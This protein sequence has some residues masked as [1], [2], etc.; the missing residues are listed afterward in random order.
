MDFS[1]PT[2]ALGPML[3]GSMEAVYFGGGYIPG[4][5]PPWVGADMEV[6]VKGG[7][8]GLPL[9][10][11]RAGFVKGEAGDHYEVKTGDVQKVRGS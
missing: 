11:F 2:K 4:G 9:I 7:K 6:G 3:K 8:S 1:D 5:K 10:D